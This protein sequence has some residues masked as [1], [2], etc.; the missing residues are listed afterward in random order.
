MSALAHIV[1]TVVPA[2]FTLLP[3]RMDTPDARA[4]MYAI[5]LQ[6]S[7]FIYRQQLGGPAMGF[8]QYEEAGVKGVMTHAA[9]RDLVAQVLD[10]MG[11]PPSLPIVHRALADNDILAAIFARLLLWTHPNVLPNVSQATKGWMYYYTLW[12]PGKPRQ[13][14]WEAFFQQAWVITKGEQPL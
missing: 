6:E 3:T 10:Q 2:A 4:M 5:G 13:S 1:K 14:T 11:Y 7:R 9:T 8:W 12:R